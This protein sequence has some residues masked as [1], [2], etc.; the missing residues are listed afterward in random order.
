MEDQKL[1]STKNENQCVICGESRNFYS[2]GACEHNSICYYCTLKNRTF[3]N[4]KKCPL[5]NSILDI[6]FI[7]NIE[8]PKSFNE[9]SKTDLSNYYKDED[10]EETG[11]YYSDISALETA[12]SLKSFK[13][14]VKYCIKE[15]PFETLKDLK[16]HLLQNHQKFFCKV[17]LK[18]GKKFI[19]EQKVYTKEEIYEHNLYGDI[20]EDIPPHHKCPFCNDLYY[21]DEILYKHMSQ[22]HFLC[23]ICKNIDKKIIFYSAL[24]NLVQHNKLFH[25]CCPYKECKDVLLISFPNQKQL[26]QHFENKHNQKNAALNEKMSRENMP[27]II[28][29]PS[30]FDVSLKKDEFNFTEFLH[31]LN[32]RCI[33]HREKLAENNN[34]NNINNNISN[35]NNF[36][37]DGIEIVYRTV[38][39]STNPYRNKKDDFNNNK[40]KNKR[41]K[42]IIFKNNDFYIKQSFNNYI[43]N[44]NEEEN[45]KMKLRE[46]DYE[47][48][49]N[50]YLEIIKS[51][52]IDLIK[53]NKVIDEEVMLPKDIQYQLIMIIDKITEN[54]KYLDL[55]NLQNFGIDLEKIN[56]LKDYLKSVEE[57]YKNDFRKELESMSFKNILVLYKYLLIAYKKITGNFY[58][59][60]FEQINED[61]YENFL[62]R[63]KNKNKKDNNNKINYN[64]SYASVSLNQNLKNENNE[65]NEIKNK[66][67]NK[68]KKFKWN[69]AEIPG[70]TDNWKKNKNKKNNYKEKQSK[71]EII[72]KD[73]KKTDQSSDS[74]S[75]E[76]N[77]ENKKTENKI[78]GNGKLANLMKSNNNAP[79]KPKKITNGNF[80]LSYFNMDE[81]F[82]PLK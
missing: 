23:E 46:L 47:F 7:I 62:P 20:D 68:K 41:K 29:D 33:H 8:D 14:P 31:K 38:Q 19:T 79:K 17:C 11:V 4:D 9:L 40:K 21:D 15:E 59:L 60:E 73:D 65:K 18:D 51:Y 10:S 58:K 52:I 54:S 26:I 67:K 70:L 45:K 56:S 24:P 32:Q 57:N 25:Y 66:K 39:T 81:D 82:P 53:K 42:D 72:K 37:T 43:E 71:T 80:K 3:Y 49:L 64:N 22:S 74:D 69:Q 77:I 55:Y 61:L 63:K 75:E 27:K 34:N 12:L 78:Y 76:E 35:Y 30:L 5:C 6:V 2:V 28:E 13:C 36:N 16:K 1:S 48:I 50:F 44:N